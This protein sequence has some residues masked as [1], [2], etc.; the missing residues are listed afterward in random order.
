MASDGWYGLVLGI[1]VAAMSYVAVVFAA[2][3]AFGAVRVTIVEPR[4]GE[5]L[6]TLCEAPL[7]LAAMIATVCLL[8]PIRWLRRRPG[9]LA[10][11]G[12]V[13][14]LLQQAI[15]F[16]VGLF[17]R[18]LSPMQQLAHFSTPSGYIYALLLI[19]FAAMP[20]LVWRVWRVAR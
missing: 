17:V 6:A 11:V 13:A 9:S 18:G 16:A 3:F 5:A 4:I 14:L 20:A 1:A 15:D 7:L 2:G 10:A 12:V 8:P 19:A